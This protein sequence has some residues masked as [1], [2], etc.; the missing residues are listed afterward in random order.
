MARR[1]DHSKEELEALIFSNACKLVEKNGLDGLSARKLATKIKYTP[2]TIYSFYKNLDELILKINANT[3]D[4]IYQQI[5]SASTKARPGKEAL[6]AIA[7]AYLAY[8]LDNHYRWKTL[9]EFSYPRPKGASLPDWYEMRIAKNFALIEKQ[10]EAL[11][12]KCETLKLQAK[13]FWSAIHGIAM[14]TMSGKMDTVK[15]AS[16]NL[17]VEE[18]CK[19]Y[20]RGL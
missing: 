9:Y 19:T 20:I 15:V 10:F 11:D 1:S 6:I 13:I 8:G 12:I 18:F 7:K 2:G 5:E 17:L 4:Q 14:L 3:L 16:V